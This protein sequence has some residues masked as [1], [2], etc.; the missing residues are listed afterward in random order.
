MLNGQASSSTDTLFILSLFRD[1][2]PALNRTALTCEAAKRNEKI[3]LNAK[4]K[5]VADLQSR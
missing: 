5:S 1:L 3:S 4:G 2:K